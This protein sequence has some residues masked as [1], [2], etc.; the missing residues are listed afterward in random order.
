MDASTMGGTT[1]TMNQPGREHEA[2]GMERRSS[3]RM[4]YDTNIRIV[5]LDD[6]GQAVADFE[7]PATNLSRGGVGVPVAAELPVGTRVVTY[8]RP[9]GGGTTKVVVGTVRSCTMSMGGRYSVG[10][11]FI[12]LAREREGQRGSRTA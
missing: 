8:L 3:P 11:E 10:I 2:S 9:V 5:V 6:V 12:R 4:P 1:T 7:A